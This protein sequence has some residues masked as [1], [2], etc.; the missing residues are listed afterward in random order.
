MRYCYEYNFFQPGRDTPDLG[1]LQVH[2]T[3]AANGYP[4]A[5]ASVR[6][7]Y[8]GVPDSTFLELSTDASGQT[9]T[10][11]LAA[12]PLEYSLTPDTEEQPYSEYTLQIEAPGYE[13]V[14][15]AGTEILPDVKALQNTVLKPLGPAGSSEEVYVFRLIPYTGPTRQKSPRRRSSPPTKPARSS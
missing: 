5:G 4:I 12:P 13:P 7:S 2:L 1:Q 3:S 10:I 15:I 14:T 9:E 8:T 6:I 11:E